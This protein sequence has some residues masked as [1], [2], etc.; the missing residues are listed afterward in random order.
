MGM[1]DERD[2]H[3]ML[4][5][6][7]SLPVGLSSLVVWVLWAACVPPQAPAQPTISLRVRGTPLSATVIVDEEALGTLDFVA[8]H[9]VAL[10]PG[11]H[12]V[13]VTAR[14]YFPSDTEVDARPGSPPVRLE[15]A[16]TPVPD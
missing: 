12:H 5:F 3:E 10:P 4:R 15:V 11:V 7:R 9:G 1:R 13:T 2:H 16:L 6:F 14:G 8:A